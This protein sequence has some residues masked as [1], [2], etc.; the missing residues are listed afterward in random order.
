MLSLVLTY[1]DPSTNV[2]TIETLRYPNMTFYSE[3]GCHIA[4]QVMIY[5]EVNKA[6]EAE[7]ED[8]FKNLAYIQ[9][10]CLK[11]R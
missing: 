9:Q 2:E 3:S 11:I 7:N 5:E 10:H 6:S 4:G 1:V 8:F